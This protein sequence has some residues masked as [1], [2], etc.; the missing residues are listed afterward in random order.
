[1][2]YGKASTTVLEFS[3]SR[4]GVL[5][6]LRKCPA[7]ADVA[8]SVDGLTKVRLGG[9]ER[10]RPDV[11]DLVRVVAALHTA[12]CT[13]R[14]PSA[15]PEDPIAFGRRIAV[16][17]PVQNPETW[18]RAGNEL[19]GLLVWL[20]DDEWDVSFVSLSAPRYNQ[21]SLV[22]DPCP[23]VLF[24]G[25]LD[26]LAGSI[27]LLAEDLDMVTLSISTNNRT[28]GVQS[29]G[30]HALRRGYPAQLKGRHRVKLEV[31]APGVD[32]ESSQ[33][34]RG[35]VCLGLGGAMASAM[36]GTELVTCENGIGAINLPMLE[37]QCGAMMSRNVHPGTLALATRLFGAVLQKPVLIREPFLFRTKRELVQGALSLG[38]TGLDR[39]TR[40]C[41]AFP[42]YDRP[43]FRC[44]SCL[45]TEL[46]LG[47][48]DHYVHISHATSKGTGAVAWYAMEQQARRIGGCLSASH[49]WTAMTAEFPIL[50]KAH[51]SVVSGWALSSE[52]AQERLVDLYRRHVS[53]WKPFA[54]AVLRSARERCA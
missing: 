54:E 21:P 15:T 2:S 5:N 38:W 39:L 9:I 40:S 10:L 51:D 50:Q 23:V 14:R 46:A 53:E 7:Q 42:R 25:G 49:P 17:V 31:D 4:T 27:M 13:V 45:Y 33:R 12:D 26:S 43:C 41:D 6:W 20:T 34:T 16:R 29:R 8:L 37:G 30:W 19:L 52:D 44:T 18:K 36:G 32:P 3:E 24:S 11:A 28:T 48:G 1:M 22:E 35:L 47:N